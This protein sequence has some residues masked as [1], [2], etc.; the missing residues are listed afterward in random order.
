MREHPPDFA[1]FAFCKAELDPAV[2]ARSSLE[3]GYDGAVMY[4]LD[5]DPLG[6]PFK[7][8]L[9]DVPESARAV[10]PNDS[11]TWQFQL[12]LQLAIV[13]QQKKS[14]GHKVQTANGH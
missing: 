1:V 12:A 8:G 3:V 4:A 2:P 7:I 11:G 13:G 6:Q 10:A 5:R 14:L 9:G